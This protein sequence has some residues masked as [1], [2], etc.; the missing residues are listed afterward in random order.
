[1]QHMDPLSGLDEG[2]DESD[3]E[4]QD[5]NLVKKQKK[6]K[7]VEEAPE[8]TVVEEPLAKR[9]KGGFSNDYFRALVNA[10][11][12]VEA[13]GNEN[14]V[15][16]QADEGVMDHVSAV[17]GGGGVGYTDLL[18][19]GLGS[20][21]ARRACASGGRGNGRGH[22]KAQRRSA[23]VGAPESWLWSRGDG[24]K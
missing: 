14:S 19:C 17:G 13:D 5:A 21:G 2:E 10:G 11:P 3:Q 1:M 9:P 12:A 7:N 6:D 15:E 18:R 20:V 4:R 8:N 22:G 24:R 23:T 16:E